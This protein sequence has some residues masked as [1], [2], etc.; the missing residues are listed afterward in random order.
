MADRPPPESCF[1]TATT[2]DEVALQ[3]SKKAKSV[4]FSAFMLSWLVTDP[5][6]SLSK[7]AM[8]G[9]IEG[10]G[11]DERSPM[12]GIE[13][14]GWWITLI[15]AACV[16]LVVW[17]NVDSDMTPDPMSRRTDPEPIHWWSS[18]FGPVLGGVVAYHIAWLF[19][20]PTGFI[21]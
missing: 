16:G 13:Y 1:M 8:M 15:I 2:R 14:D 20:E 10:A 17:L 6:L 11:P 7:L 5:A 18:F 3:R 19:H 4:G 21:F 9:S 12:W